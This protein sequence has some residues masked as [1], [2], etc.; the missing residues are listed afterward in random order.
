VTTTRSRVDVYVDPACPLAWLASRWLLEV[1]RY[2][3]LD[4]RFHLVSLMLLNAE[5]DVADD[6]RTL[7]NRSPAAARVLMAATEQCG[8]H[9]LLDLYTAFGDA[10]FTAE[11]HEVVHRPRAH[12]ERWA[13]A[14]REAIAK[15]L[16]EVGLAGDLAQAA[17]TTT[18]DDAPRANQ[19]A[20]LAQ[21]GT[22]VLTSITPASSGR[23]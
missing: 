6:Y 18:Y 4:L 2:R 3:D 14:M 16:A 7:L 11:N 21:V 13:H 23:C 17:D 9:T 19:H 12:F 10:M 22:P 15:A 1:Q 5:R 20:A 8:Q